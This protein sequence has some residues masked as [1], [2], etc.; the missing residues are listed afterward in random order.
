MQAESFIKEKLLV[1]TDGSY[2]DAHNL[3]G[4]WQKFQA[5]E[6]EVQANADN[7]EKLASRADV[8]CCLHAPQ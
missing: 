7:I 2:R 6:A 4:K 8:R 1:A 3:Q 5:F